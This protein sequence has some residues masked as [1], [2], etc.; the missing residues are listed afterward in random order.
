MRRNFT[1]SLVNLAV[2]EAEMAAKQMTPTSMLP[3]I[4]FML[5]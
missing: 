2:V 1:S 3:R 4:D 5:K